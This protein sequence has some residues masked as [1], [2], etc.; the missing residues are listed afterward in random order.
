MPAMDKGVC[1]NK[2]DRQG[3]TNTLPI[4]T[5]PTYVEVD[6]ASRTISKNCPICENK[7]ET[8]ISVDKKF[9]CRK[10]RDAFTKKQ[11]YE[12]YKTNCRVCGKEFLPPRPAEGAQFCSY[13]CSGIAN[14]KDRVDRQGYWFVCV[15]GHPKSSKQG[16][17]GE[18]TL[19]MEKHIG[20]HLKPEEVVHHVNRDR[21][22]NRIQNL[23]LMTDVEH[24]RLH[25]I[26]DNY[27]SHLNGKEVHGEVK[28]SF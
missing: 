14:R 3:A 8:Y 4:L 19:I 6:M 21:K 20:R 22:D 10:C 1:Y 7:F 13:K 24:K 28:Y 15:P 11:T 17:V 27:Q 18:H 23:Q 2:T 5:K 26:E 16:Y 9:C 12:K 25:A